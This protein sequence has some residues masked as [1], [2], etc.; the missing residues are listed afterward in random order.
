VDTARAAADPA[1][2]AAREEAAYYQTIEEFFVARRGDPLV[3][4]S[5][6]WVLIWN[7]RKAG[8]P[9]RVVLRGIG[10]ALDSHAHS[11]GRKRKVLRL[12]YCAAEVEAARDRWQRALSF[13]GEAQASVA[14]AMDGFAEALE[15][16]VDLGPRA[17]QLTRETAARLREWAREASI[18]PP[19]LETLT[20]RLTHV[21]RE[22]LEAIRGEMDPAVLAA[23]R[24]KTDSDLAPYRARMPARVLDQIRDEAWARGV[25]ARHGL[26][27]LSLFHL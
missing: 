11:W 8:L 27:R 3:L 19:S 16:A 6:D 22:L 26:P 12:A 1:S 2:P 24:D 15:R 25:L 9:L 5:A 17:A 20:T 4:S 14:A 10:D 21:E 13:E 23:I 7:W 18:A